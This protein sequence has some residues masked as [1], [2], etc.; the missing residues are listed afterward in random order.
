MFNVN[1]SSG[2]FSSKNGPSSDIPLSPEHGGPILCMD[3]NSDIVVTG[4]T[5]H[6]LRVY[7]L[8]NGK[9]TK[10]YILLSIL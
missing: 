9:Q 8:S 10:Q 4:S 7:N 3:N 1:L 2:S 5:D 6:G